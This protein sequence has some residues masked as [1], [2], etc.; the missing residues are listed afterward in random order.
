MAWVIMLLVLVAVLLKVIH[1]LIVHPHKCRGH[2]EDGSLL[3]SGM[4]AA[5]GSGALKH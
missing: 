3:P 2:E 5:L 1:F 4:G